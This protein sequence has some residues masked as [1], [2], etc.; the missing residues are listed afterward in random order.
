MLPSSMRKVRT[1]RGG[2]DGYRNTGTQPRDGRSR[3]EREGLRRKEVRGIGASGGIGVETLWSRVWWQSSRREMGGGRVGRGNT[4]RSLET[5]HNGK[6][7]K[8]QGG[9]V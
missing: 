4:R 5:S 3:P 6:K 8:R 2:R 1:A 9:K 7:N